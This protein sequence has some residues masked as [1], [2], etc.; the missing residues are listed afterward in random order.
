M[1]MSEVRVPLKDRTV[2]FVQKSTVAV[3][4]GVWDLSEQLAAQ[5]LPQELVW[6][7]SGIYNSLAKRDGVDNAEEFMSGVF[8]HLAGKRVAQELAK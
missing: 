2:S 1:L 3:H 6:L 5:M 4:T 7:V 8:E